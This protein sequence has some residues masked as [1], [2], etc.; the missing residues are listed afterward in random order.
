MSAAKGTETSKYKRSDNV[1][2]DFEHLFDEDAPPKN[3]KK[4]GTGFLYYKRL[5][6]KNKGGFCLSLFMFILKNLPVWVIPIITANIID[7]ATRSF[8]Q[9][10][11]TCSACSPLPR[12]TG[13]KTKRSLNATGISAGS[14]R[15]GLR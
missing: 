8:R 11:R 4:R 6:Q 3:G 13:W 2:P 5:L 10:F 9:S 1:I 15:G 14:R 12:R 7:L